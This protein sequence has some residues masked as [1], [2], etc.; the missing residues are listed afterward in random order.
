MWLVR[1]SRYYG[2][3]YNWC[4]SLLTYVCVSVKDTSNCYCFVV[5]KH[6]HVCILYRNS[7]TSIIRNVLEISKRLESLLLT[8]VGIIFPRWESVGDLLIAIDA[9][10]NGILD[11]HAIALV[12][13]KVV[14]QFTLTNDV[15]LKCNIQL[16]PIKILSIEP[17]QLIF[18]TMPLR[19]QTG[20]CNWIWLL[21]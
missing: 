20:D 19:E 10:W 13:S 14:L 7:K 16:H 8:G 5:T 21:S 3:E 2:Y 11:D 4:D 18:L 17:I 6:V 1:H 9:S 15:I 12:V